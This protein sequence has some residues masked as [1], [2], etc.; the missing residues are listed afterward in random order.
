MKI[1]LIVPPSGFQLDERVYPM[2]GVLKV[3]AVLEI[4]G[5][6]VDVLDLSGTSPMAVY[7]HAYQ[8]GPSDVYGFTA[9]MPQMPAVASI[10]P[11]L[12]RLAPKARLILGGAHPTLVN[13]AARAGVHRSQRMLGQLLDLF[14]CVVAGDGERAVFQAIRPDAPS[15]IDADRP[16]DFMF[17]SPAAVSAGPW[18]ARDLIKLRSYRCWVDGQEA[19]SVIAQLGCPFGCRFCG[20][21]NSPTFRRVRLRNVDSVVGELVDIYERFRYRAFMFLDDELNVSRSFPDLLRAIIAA[22]ERLGVEWRLCGLLK[23]ELFTAEQ[24]GLM[25][26]AGF[27]KVLVG[28]ESGHP[29]ILENMKKGATVDDNTRAVDLAHRAGLKIK[30]LMSL[31]HPGESADT[32]ATTR[33]WLLSVQPDEFDATVLTVYPGTPYHDEATEDVKGVWTYRAPNG[34]RLHALPIDQLKDTPYYK[35]IPGNY[36]S[37]VWTDDLTSADLVQQRDQLEADVRDRLKIPWPRGAAAVNYEHSMGL[38]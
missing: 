29:R 17:L 6:N 11:E 32:I 3:G 14:D 4:A 37:Y 20:G 9:T 31:G 33:D 30:A 15:L 2:L 7:R 25:F 12:R 19:T 22:Q 13:V 28:F 27:R 24:A 35:G 18:P 26:E 34:D 10:L 8:H 23:S 1:T 16:D 38:R 5:H 21:R 36:Q